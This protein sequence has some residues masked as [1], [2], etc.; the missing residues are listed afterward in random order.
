MAPTR[1]VYNNERVAAVL[2]FREPPRSMAV[3]TYVRSVAYVTPRVNGSIEHVEWVP[4]DV[5][6]RAEPQ[7]F[8]L[9]TL[10]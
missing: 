4:D 10:S 9:S 7:T 1:H 3:T 8:R 2:A 6:L 5:Y